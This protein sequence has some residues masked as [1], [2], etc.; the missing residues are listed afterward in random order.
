[1]PLRA[2]VSLSFF[3]FHGLRAG[4]RSAALDLSRLLSNRPSVFDTLEFRAAH[5]WT[6]LAAPQRS[7]GARSEVKS[8]SSIYLRQGCQRKS[9]RAAALLDPI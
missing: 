1:M 2:C 8:T 4:K 3:V 7:Q 6:A 5:F 9:H